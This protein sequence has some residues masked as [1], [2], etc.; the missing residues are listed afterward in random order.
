MQNVKKVGIKARKW[1][2]F[3]TKVNKMRKIA[4]STESVQKKKSQFLK[5][6]KK[7]ALEL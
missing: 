2:K 4:K 6:A 3:E 1:S 5:R 7:P